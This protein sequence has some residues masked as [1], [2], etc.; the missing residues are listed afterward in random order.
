MKRKNEKRQRDL[1]KEQE[2]PDRI[3]HFKRGDDF[4]Y[5]RFFMKYVVDPYRDSED[6][7]P[8]YTHDTYK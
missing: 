7:I 2:D 5:E 6:E 3:N 8:I 4:D 1:K